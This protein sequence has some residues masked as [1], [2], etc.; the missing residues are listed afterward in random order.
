MPG[1]LKCKIFSH[2]NSLHLQQIYAGFVIL[3]QNGALDL[4]QVVERKDLRD[5]RRPP[6][7]RRAR[8]HHLTVVLNEKIRLYYDLH[9]GAEIDETE[10]AR[11]DFY[12][13]RSFATAVVD[14]LAEPHK[15]FPLGLNYLIYSSDA[16]CF[17]RARGRLHD[18]LRERLE[19]VVRGAAVDRFL[20]HGIYTPRVSELHAPPNFSGA[21]KAL[22]MARAWNPTSVEAQL[23]KNE[24]AEINETRAECIRLLRKEF[25][26]RFYGG[27]AHDDYSRVHFADCLLPDHSLAR[28]R[29][30]LK[31]LREFAVCAATTGLLGST[32]WKMGEYTA[33]SKAIVCEPLNYVAPGDFGRDKNYLEF[34][35]PADC[36]AAVARLF[37]DHR[38]RGEIMMNNYRYYQAYLKPDALVL[39]T[40]AIALGATAQ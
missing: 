22:F 29:N 34:T 40:L 19:T 13:K 28:K 26:A 7:L 21:P 6:H 1:K 33:F 8:E 2:S 18:N 4:R 9:D 5:N 39:R 17:L 25:G 30:Y 20:P 12:F 32:G 14:F 38:L 27:F 15:V 23:H 3:A 35:T 16:D 37:D 10:L 24:I 36:V 31:L 11:A